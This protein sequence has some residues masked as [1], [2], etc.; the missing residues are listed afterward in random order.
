MEM[1][2]LRMSVDLIDLTEDKI[3]YKIQFCNCVLNELERLC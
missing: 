2:F 1:D 3:Q